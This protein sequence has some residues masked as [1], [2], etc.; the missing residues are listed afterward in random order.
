M[1]ADCIRKWLRYSVYMDTCIF[2]KIVAG[3]VPAHR[4][5]E[6]E[7]YV[8]FLDIRPLSA[9]HT[10]V[11]PKEHHR[12]VWD[13]TGIGDYFAV[14][15]KVAKALQQ[16]SGTDEVHMKVIGEEVEHAHVWVFPSPDKAQGD[17]NDF[18]TNAKNLSSALT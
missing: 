13:V 12:F 1:C 5:Y 3:T 10:L 18:E 8:A 11:I 4:V 7:H 9:G 2:C 15:Q 17:K 14:V 16:I 6:D